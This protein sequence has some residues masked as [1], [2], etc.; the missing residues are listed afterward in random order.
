MGS[1]YDS[2]R[3]TMQ[4]SRFSSLQASKTSFGMRD[5]TIGDGGI[6]IRNYIDSNRDLSNM[7]E[8]AL[9]AHLRQAENLNSGIASKI[10]TLKGGANTKVAA[11]QKVSKRKKDFDAA[12]DKIL[13]HLDLTKTLEIGK[14]GKLLQNLENCRSAQQRIGSARALAARNAKKSVETV[15]SIKE[16]FK[17]NEKEV[18]PL[19]YR[20]DFSRL[21]QLFQ[22]SLVIKYYAKKQEADPRVKKEAMRE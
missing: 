16:L 9:T 7:N 20:C 8:K 14:K 2:N 10:S 4:G 17:V 13:A 22:R 5:G 1:Q 18:N 12:K 19:T 15:P 3:Q 21:T 11:G 6:S